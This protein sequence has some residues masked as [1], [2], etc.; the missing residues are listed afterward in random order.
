[1]STNLNVL[2]A[3]DSPKHKKP[4][5]DELDI[6]QYILVYHPGYDPRPLL[7]FL[8]A[9][10]ASGRYGLPFCVVLDAC[11]ILANNKGGTLRVSNSGTDLTPPDAKTFLSPGSYTYHVTG[12]ETHAIFWSPIQILMCSP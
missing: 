5:S 9:F 11:R 3:G 8:V 7:L 6:R 12:G 4:P 1:M 10:P 2:Y